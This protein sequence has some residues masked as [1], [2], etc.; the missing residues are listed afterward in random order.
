[1][2]IACQSWGE[3]CVQIAVK[4]ALKGDPGAGELNLLYIYIYISLLV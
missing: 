1:M 4:V 3:F 2:V